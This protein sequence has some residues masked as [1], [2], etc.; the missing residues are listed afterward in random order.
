[1]DK[2]SS[3][4]GLISSVENQKNKQFVTWNLELGN[5]LL[6]HP[7]ST[8]LILKKTNEIDIFDFDGT[9][10]QT[11]YSGPFEKDFLGVTGDGRLLILANLNPQKNSF[12]DIYAVGVK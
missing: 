10:V 5:L 6:W 7:N 4:E 2:T 1:M 3:A 11:V 12:P 8:Q 9:H